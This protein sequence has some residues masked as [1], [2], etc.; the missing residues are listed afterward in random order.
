MPESR[1]ATGQGTIDIGDLQLPRDFEALLRLGPPEGQE[2]LNPSG[3]AAHRVAV[4]FLR[5]LLE[6]VR[7]RLSIPED[8]RGGDSDENAWA[9]AFLTLSMYYEVAI[10]RLLSLGASPSDIPGLT[11]DSSVAEFLT[12]S[13]DAAQAAQYQRDAFAILQ[14][15]LHLATSTFLLWIG[16]YKTQ[17]P[18]WSLA[19]IEAVAHERLAELRD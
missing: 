15:Y 7:G 8:V 2:S 9:V 1:P 11:L 6:L 12:G 14:V 13:S 4:A 3:E 16:Q 18:A 5:N 19:P 17:L 10:R